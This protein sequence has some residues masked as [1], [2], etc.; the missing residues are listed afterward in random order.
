MTAPVRP[1]V[2]RQSL[3]D[4]LTREEVNIRQLFGQLEQ[5][6]AGKDKITEELEKRVCTLESR[7]QLQEKYSSKD[8]LIIEKN[9]PLIITKFVA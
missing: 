8:T 4:R 7:V 1:P 2:F 9:I 3:A 5:N 6:L